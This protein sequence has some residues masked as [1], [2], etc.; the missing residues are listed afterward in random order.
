MGDG[1]LEK[2]YIFFSK[3]HSNNKIMLLNIL[4]IKTST[5]IKI[6]MANRRAELKILNAVYKL[7]KIIQFIFS[8]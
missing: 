2:G 3:M 8:K 4:S 7:P 5:L 1:I 6:T